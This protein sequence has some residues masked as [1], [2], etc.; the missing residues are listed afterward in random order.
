MGDTGNVVKHEQEGLHDLNVR[1]RHCIPSITQRINIFKMI[2]L[3]QFF[4]A[5][6]KNRTTVDLPP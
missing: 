5:N 4:F 3:T 6:T 2:D 1:V